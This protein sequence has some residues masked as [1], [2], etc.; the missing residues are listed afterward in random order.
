M[1][2]EYF[3][4][5]PLIMNNTISRSM[6]ETPCFVAR[7]IDQVLPFDLMKTEVQLERIYAIDDDG[8]ITRAKEL[9]RKMQIVAKESKRRMD[10]IMSQEHEK[11]NRKR[12]TRKI[13]E[14]DTTA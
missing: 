12:K 2:D 13:E 8:A 3:S 7:G 10:E 1:G 11:I 6:G 9:R 14:G 5:I 4:I